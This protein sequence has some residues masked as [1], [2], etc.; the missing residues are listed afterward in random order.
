[1]GLGD[2]DAQLAVAVLAALLI[3]TL[4]NAASV[5]RAPA[6]GIAPY[7]LLI[8]QMKRLRLSDFLEVIFQVRGFKAELSAWTAQALYARIITY[9]DDNII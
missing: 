8:L 5:S 9:D 1:M 3:L 2:T 7:I 6:P 4:L